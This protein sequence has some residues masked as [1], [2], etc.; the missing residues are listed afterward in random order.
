MKKHHAINCGD[1]AV[2]AEG[3]ATEAGTV[4]SEAD[5]SSAHA[6]VCFTAEVSAGGGM[7]PLFAGASLPAAASQAAERRRANTAVRGAPA[8]AEEL[9]LRDVLAS[10]RSSASWTQ[11]AITSGIMMKQGEA[12]TTFKKR[13]FSCAKGSGEVQYFDAVRKLFKI[14]K[15][16]ILLRTVEHIVADRGSGHVR[17]DRRRIMLYTPTRTWVLRADRSEEAQEWVRVFE[18]ESGVIASE[19]PPGGAKGAAAARAVSSDA[20][21]VEARRSVV[22][23]TRV[24]TPPPLYP[25]V[26]H[27][28]VAV[29]APPVVA[30]AESSAVPTS[31][32]TGLATR[33]GKRPTA[34]H[35][36]ML[37]RDR[38]LASQYD[39][40]YGAGAARLVI[41][42]ADVA[43]AAL[44]KEA[45]ASTAAAHNATVA[46]GRAAACYS[47]ERA[48]HSVTAARSSP[49]SFESLQNKTSSHEMNASCA[50]ASPGSVARRARQRSI[51]GA[52]EVHSAV[53]R[54]RGCESMDAQHRLRQGRAPSLGNAPLCS[55]VASTAAAHHSTV[56]SGR[57]AARC[58]AQQQR[59]ALAVPAAASEFAESQECFCSIPGAMDPSFEDL[60]LDRDLP[61]HRA[62]LGLPF[63]ISSVDQVCA[64]LGV[65]STA[66]APPVG[67]SAAQRALERTR[68]LLRSMPPRGAFGAAAMSH[69]LDSVVSTLRA[70][71]A[72]SA[73]VVPIC[74]CRPL[75]TAARASEYDE[76]QNQLK[77]AIASGGVHDFA[78]CVVAS[79]SSVM[80]EVAAGAT[81]SAAV[82]ARNAVRDAVKAKFGDV[83]A[84]LLDGALPPSS[85]PA[86]RGT[87]AGGAGGSPTR[88]EV[89]ASQ[90]F[91]LCVVARDAGTG[92]TCT[93]SVVNT[94]DGSDSGAEYHPS[95]P[96]SRLTSGAAA[97]VPLFERLTI[98]ELRDVPRAHICD[99]AWWL[100][101]LRTQFFPCG[102]E[103][104]NSGPKA[105]YE[106][107]LPALNQRPLA[108]N[109][110]RCG[111]HAA[112]A[113]PAVAGDASGVRCVVAALVPLLRGFG[114]APAAAR[115]VSDVLVPV[116]FAQKAKRALSAD[117][118]ALVGDA[119]VHAAASAAVLALGNRAA[120]EVERD[121]TVMSAAHCAEVSACVG[122]MRASVEAAKRADW[123]AALPARTTSGAASALPTRDAARH[124]RFGRFRLDDGGVNGERLAG[125]M[126]PPRILRPIEL[127]L[128]KDHGEVRSMDEA[129]LALR[130]AVELCALLDNQSDL[131]ANSARLRVALVRHVV[132]RTLPLPLPVTHSERDRRCFWSAE[133]LLRGMQDEIV[134]LLHS[135]THHY[136]A[137]SLSVA[138]TAA[139][140]AARVLTLACIATLTDAVV[141]RCASDHS[142]AL[143]RH[144]SGEAEGPT[145]PFAIAIGPRLRALSTHMSLRAPEL[146]TARSGVLDYFDALG[147][148][149]RDDHI[150]FDY[151]SAMALGAGDARL[152]NQLCVDRG[153]AQGARGSERAT[154]ALRYLTG[155]E[156]G[157]IDSEPALGLFRD[158]AFVLQLLMCGGGNVPKEMWSKKDALLQWSTASAAIA[159][160]GVEV[161]TGG[162]YD[163][164]RVRITAFGGRQIDCTAQAAAAAAAARE[165]ASKNPL[166]W[167]ASVGRKQHRVVEISS[168]PTVLVPAQQRAGRRI[169]TEEDVLHLTGS[170]RTLPFNV[171]DDGDGVL[172]PML[173]EPDVELLLQ[174]LTA[175]LLRIPLAAAF[176]ADPVRID[177]LVVGNVNH[178]AAIFAE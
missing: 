73:A 51:M 138:N 169:T 143:S 126:A 178:G 87:V 46:G 78:K 41:A 56:A 167:L 69:V 30:Q 93:V 119:A 24:H 173:S 135:L 156:R 94:R 105:L 162:S 96:C 100:A 172:F 151:T 90:H 118:T 31:P 2:R 127:T 133:P 168:D 158:I 16:S 71:P 49:H 36:R 107:L 75:G 5:A 95:R 104:A 103:G 116:A 113:P 11:S 91:V 142:S 3:A 101:A 22:D 123:S 161:A 131:V 122:A 82:L 20:D 148:L 176:F 42:D 8:G 175:P 7:T 33:L 121:D 86:A 89:D 21:V 74:W 1:V 137:A 70:L 109:P 145:R 35:L 110:D 97:A 147:A 62:P 44:L 17:Y 141:R 99:A 45:V 60:L 170:L 83:G 14:P 38:T 58:A 15:G 98:I 159:R 34:A 29:S 154:L 114:A 19:H 125:G 160:P 163:A 115:L 28:D 130:H 67:C 92:D 54:Q 171:F 55:A 27:G 80:D 81:K 76:L 66:S 18:A 84:S 53:A 146:A 68:D 139:F 165:P 85:A 88:V 32:P 12:T 153:L 47:R 177:V 106:N 48:Q 134:R 26:F 10:G 77:S 43:A 23:P 120:R 63:L 13:F 61:S 117:P 128:V 64:A 57:A 144:Y 50:F 155:E 112:W 166:K 111:D 140:N 157:L 124:A 129:A 40:E 149:V 25:L 132:T 37:L 164:P 65:V 39:A 52:P 6:G 9:S 72:G 59:A 152:V 79:A 136:I 108:A 150:L 102:I 174:F 4:Q